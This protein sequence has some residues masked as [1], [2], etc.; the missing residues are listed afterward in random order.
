M[1]M[2]EE[3]DKIEEESDEDEDLSTVKGRE[4]QVDDDEASS[5]EAAWS[6]G[7]YGEDE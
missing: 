5:W 1:N 4:K 6:Q 7:Y 3:W 2:T